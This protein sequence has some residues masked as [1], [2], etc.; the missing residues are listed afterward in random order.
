MDDH[1]L[2]TLERFTSQPRLG[3]Y[4]AASANDY[5]SFLLYCWNIQLAEALIPTIAIFEVTLR[6]AVHTALT[7]H[8]QTDWWFPLVLQPD[9]WA[10]IEKLIDRITPTHGSSP[11]SGKVIS[12]ITFGFWQKLFARK[13]SDLWWPNRA[14]QL[15][16]GVFP[17]HPNPA[18]DTRN[19]LELRLEYF[20]RLRNR[21]VHHETIFDGIVP[22]NRPRLPVD[23]L[24][25]QLIETLAWLDEDAANLAI[26]LS[27]FNDVIDPSAFQRLESII[28][29]H[30]VE[31]QHG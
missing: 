2:L 5:E 21:A 4:R 20:V 16:L 3:P 13:Y 22:P 31:R 11:T 27:R 23:T 29:E 25:E 10:N 19:Q 26:C 7:A 12:E 18:R 17:H 9:A 8:T 28:R 15:L 1:L 30:F 14:P 24:H 6:N